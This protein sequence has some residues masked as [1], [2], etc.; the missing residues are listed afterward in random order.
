MKRKISN[1]KKGILAILIW[2]FSLAIF[3]QNITL[4]GT[5]TDT[6]GEPLIGVSVK[7][8]GTSNG[9]ATDAEGSFTLSNVPPNAV[10]DVSYIGMK[11]Q[12]LNI[13]GRTSVNVILEEDAEALEEVVVVAYGVQ[14]KVSVTGAISSVDT[15]NL[16]Q[17]SS[18]NLSAALA[19]RLPGLT[20]MQTSGQP[21]YDEV[22]L[23]LR[24]VGTLNDASPLILI[25]GIPRSNID[26]IDPNEV[27]SIS[28]LKDASATAVFGVR[29]ANGVV[30]ITTRRGK[31]GKSELS[32]SVDQSIQQFLVKADRLH[33]WEFAELRNQAYTNDHPGAT[34]NEMPFTQYMIDKYRS[35]E[36]PVFYPD[37]DVF[38]DY[39]RDWAPQTRVNANFNGGGDRF[40]YFLN[41]GYIGQGGNF[42]TEP[43]SFL[44]YDPSYKMNRYNFRGNIDYSIANNLKA[45]L[46]IATYIEKMNT[47]QTIDLFGGSV[48][49]MV[50]NMISYT[51]GTPPTDPGPT[52]VAGYGVPPHEM[53]AQSGQDR[54]TYGEINRRGYRQE[55][56]NNMNSSLSLDW[57]LGFI[58]KGLSAKGMI[59]FDSH[60]STVLQGVRGVDYYAFNVARNTGE[61]NGYSAIRTNQDVAIRLSKSMS[62]RYY[63]NYQASLNYARSFG[64]HNL[65]GMFLYQRDNWDQYGADLP[66]NI[67]GL[68]GRVTYNYEDRYLAEFNYGYNGSEQFA[69]NNRFGSFP[70]FSVG[71][72][73][74]NEKFL[75]KISSISNLKLR[76]SYGL[77]GND[78]LGYERFLYQSF[79]NMGSGI[80]PT[81]G[82]GQS[83]VQ[84]RM[85]NEA[86]QWEMAKKTNLG[87]D[88]EL[89][90]SLSLTVDLFQEHRDKILISR[91]TIPQ[92][93]GVPLENIPKV[94]IGEVNNKGFEAE[95]TY[96]KVVN[97]D[98]SFLVKG[99]YAYNK[100]TVVYADEVQYGEDYTYRNRVTGYSIGQQFGYKID[101]SNGN[102]Y[103]NTQEELDNLPEYQMGGTPR[104]GDFMYVDVNED[105]VIN[106]RDMVPIGYP[107]IPRVT[108]GI[109]SSLNYKNVD[110]SFLLTGVGQTHRYTNGWGVTEFA[111]VGFYS[112][113]H[114]QAWTAGRYANGEEILYPALGMS[115]GVSQVPN[116][117]FIM[118]RSFLR[119]KS[120]EMGYTFPDKWIV[121]LG[122]S[123][124]RIYLNGNNLFTIKKMPI[125]TVDPEQSDA[126]VYPLTKMVNFGLNIT[127]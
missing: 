78:K 67:V 21:G 89:L 92:L 123:R 48:A 101:Y 99:N 118:D 71:W 84:G 2:T 119:L 72:I 12:T 8:Q 37:R 103:I 13:S 81:L 56:T 16:K 100:N 115:S 77:T 124:I 7:I 93:Q 38:H 59:A 63:V 90:K 4:T 98:F 79:I 53:V 111:L 114:K 28:I 108:Y 102:G 96:K 127:F 34:E 116:D 19:G 36:D 95:L 70:A 69:P 62:T 74:S 76:A 83:V 126:L 107:T 68:V 30:M 75:K 87:I 43:E 29:G 23:Y 80:F 31:P 1:Q 117:V 51:W 11:T 24:G 105:G 97:K 25:D 50:Q 3:A 42:K 65:T 125:D 66:Y 110:F 9:T 32:I 64:K 27:E 91:N 41:A 40:T 44:G 46:N 88:V 17:S 55:T 122:I 6:K 49:G 112:G 82:R 45:S 35:G 20:V 54:N 109:S 10:L 33:S 104:L 120:I 26:K 47:P 85:G 121:P 52:T 94:N 106:D 39:F 61:T 57:G 5:V 73:A 14:K 22:N 15:K 60:A 113:W 18:A 58:T 86:L